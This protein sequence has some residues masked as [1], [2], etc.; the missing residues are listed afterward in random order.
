MEHLK[1]CRKLKELLKRTT[2]SFQC[3]VLVSIAK[4]NTIQQLEQDIKLAACL[5]RQLDSNLTSVNKYI[6]TEAHQINYFMRQALAKVFELIDEVSTELLLTKYRG[7][8]I[9]YKNHPYVYVEH[10]LESNDILI[11]HL[12]EFIN[13]LE[14]Y[15]QSD[16]TWI[17]GG[18]AC[19]L[20]A[21]SG[22]G[23]AFIH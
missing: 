3:Q 13:A 15:Q 19:I 2:R 10:N 21:I 14:T 22:F 7:L 9:K 12:E 18:I 17:I 8:M 1:I 20:M 4:Y 6:L 11:L 5:Y 23:Y 16:T